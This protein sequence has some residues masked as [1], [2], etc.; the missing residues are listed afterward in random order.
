MKFGSLFVPSP[1]YIQF[2]AYEEENVQVL[3]VVE[4]HIEF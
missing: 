4:K 3:S 2:R 1:M